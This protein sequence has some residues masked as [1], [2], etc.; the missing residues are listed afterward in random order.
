MRP[1]SL[2][3][4]FDPESEGLGCRVQRGSGVQFKLSFF[5]A[6]VAHVS[7]DLFVDVRSSLH[8]MSS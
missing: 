6:T 8:G 2:C 3:S 4:G 1:A 7:T 5:W